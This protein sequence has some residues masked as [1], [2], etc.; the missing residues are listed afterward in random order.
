MILH[1]GYIYT[2]ER[3][4]T[5]KSTLR[6][7]SR[8]CKSRCHTNLSMD[9]FLSQ[10][11]SHSHAPQLDRVPA[12]QLKNDIKARAVIADEPTSSILH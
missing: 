7:Q 5:T 1:E 8:D 6:C 2:V 11:T 10:P 9:T 3:T 4:T 12:I